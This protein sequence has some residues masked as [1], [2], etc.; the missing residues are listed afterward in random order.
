M[1]VPVHKVLVPVEQMFVSVALMLGQVAK[2]LGGII[3]ITSL[4]YHNIYYIYQCV[5]Y[6]FL[7]SF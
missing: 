7:R 2:I 4:S 6:V 1:F 5:G 3:N